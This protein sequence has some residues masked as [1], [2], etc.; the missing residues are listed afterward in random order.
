M[1]TPEELNRTMDFI[2]RQQAQ[3]SVDMQKV[4]EN[5]QQF[6]AKVEQLSTRVEQLATVVERNH[7]TMM[8]GFAET[9]G[10][11]RELAANQ[12]RLGKIL[13]IQSRRMERYED[14][15]Q[16]TQRRQEELHKDSLAR[17]DRILD[18]LM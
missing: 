4:S 7:E 17:L 16:E 3:F 15:Q 14:W 8:R 18:R 9:R 2:L 5:L 1:M 13:D 12:L 11:T 6:S 10:F